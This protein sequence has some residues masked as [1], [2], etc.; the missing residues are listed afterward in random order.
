[1]RGSVVKLEFH[2][3]VTDTDPAPTL[4]MRLSCNF[5]NVY[6]IAYRIQCTFTRVHVRIAN[7]HPREDPPR[8]KSCVSDKSARI[9]ARACPDRTNGQHYRS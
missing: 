8:G 6:T 2:G 9:I 5:V 4:E 7:R 1:M 3:T